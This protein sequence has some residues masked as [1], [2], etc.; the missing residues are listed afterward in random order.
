MSDRDSLIWERNRYESD[1]DSCSNR[2]DSY[3]EKIDTL[4]TAKPYITSLRESFVAHK[5]RV[6]SFRDMSEYAYSTHWQGDTVTTFISKMDTVVSEELE[7]SSG[8][9]ITMKEDIEDEIRRLKKLRRDERF[10][11]ANLES[12]ISDLTDA[13]N[14]IFD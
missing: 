11:L 13:I 12:K 1:C 3:T 2:I 10:S 14:N 6:G 4:K 8:D 9:L 7:Y 5:N